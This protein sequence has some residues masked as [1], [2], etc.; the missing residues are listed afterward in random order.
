MD[1]E[2]QKK[3]YSKR[4]KFVKLAEKRVLNAL[5][6]ISLVGNLA[7]KNNYKYDEKDVRKIIKAL[8]DEI[9]DVDSRFKNGPSGKK[10]FKL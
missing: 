1:S 5:K 10:L 3:T 8:N 7:N 2:V 9:K 4:E 6:A